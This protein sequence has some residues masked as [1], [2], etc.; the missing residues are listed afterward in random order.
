M[1]VDVQGGGSRYDKPLLGYDEARQETKNKLHAE[2][3][4]VLQKCVEY[5][6]IEETEGAQIL[7]ILRCSLVLAFHNKEV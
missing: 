5:S 4:C 2:M 3:W 6:S 1:N 7:A